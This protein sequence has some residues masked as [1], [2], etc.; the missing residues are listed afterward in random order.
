MRRRQR[1]AGDGEEG[2]PTALDNIIVVARRAGSGRPVAG[3]GVSSM[4]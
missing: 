4:T 1:C 3:L 2:Y